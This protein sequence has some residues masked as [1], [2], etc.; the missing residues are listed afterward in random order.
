VEPEIL[1]KSDARYWRERLLLR[2]YRFAASGEAENDLAALIE[3]AGVE[4]Y[5]PLGTREPEAAARKAQSIYQM[6][7]KRGWD[8][9]CRQFPR[10]LMLGFEWCANPILWTYTTIH[11]LTAPTTEPKPKTGGQ[12]VLVVES[13]AGIRRAL[14]WCLNQHT[15]LSAVACESEAA[16]ATA[17]A[18][19]SPQMVLLNRNMAG[20]IGFESPGQLAPIRQNVMALTYSVAVDGDRLFVSTPGGAEGYLLKRVKPE[21]L[22]EPVLDVAGRPN[23]AAKNLLAQVKTYFKGLLQPRLDPDAASLARL[24]P[25]EREVLA[26]LSKGCVDKEIAQALN[27]SVWTVHG[28]VKK[29]FERLRVRTRTEAVIRYLE[30]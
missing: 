19:Q 21:K 24:T 11:T 2:R 28:H 25:R 13:E 29:I 22:L 15:G 4:Y 17:F 7:V 18:P 30:K 5:F 12:H 3:H 26:L 20:R 9:V 6:A 8:S 27:I 16:F 14:V 10:E 23:F 1:P